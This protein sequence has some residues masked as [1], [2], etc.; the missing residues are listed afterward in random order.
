MD[1]RTTA[2]RTRWS[3]IV[4]VVVNVTVGPAAACLYP[5]GRTADPGDEVSAT[6]DDPDVPEVGTSALESETDARS[7]RWSRLRRPRRRE[8]VGLGAVIAG[9]AADEVADA[10]AGE[11]SI[12]ALLAV[13]EVAAAAPV[14]HVVAAAPDEAVGLL[15]SGQRV[16]A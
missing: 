15:G 6:A 4:L 7:R 2:A 11:Q 13:E 5:Q 3:R 9:T 1:P 8:R 12:V 16:V 10:V 14:Q